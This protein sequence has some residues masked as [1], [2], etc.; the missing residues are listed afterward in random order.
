MDLSE[1]LS[2]SQ[3]LDEYIVTYS[4]G[5]RQKIF[6]IAALMHD[7]DAFIL[8]EPLTGLDPRHPMSSRD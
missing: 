7:P 6:L 1:R 2:L 8:D 3:N 4:H 5:M